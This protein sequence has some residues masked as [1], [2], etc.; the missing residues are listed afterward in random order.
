M[1]P[2]SKFELSDIKD[3]NEMEI[4][5]TYN[6]KGIIVAVVVNKKSLKSYYVMIQPDT[7]KL[8]PKN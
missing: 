4:R 3:L 6:D 8:T 2:I 7:E 1:V 5:G